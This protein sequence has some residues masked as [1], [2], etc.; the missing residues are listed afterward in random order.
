MFWELYDL[1]W[2][3]EKRLEEPELIAQILRFAA[4]VEADAQMR[5]AERILTMI[6]EGRIA[7]IKSYLEE[8]IS[9]LHEFQVRIDRDDSMHVFCDSMAKR[10]DIKSLKAVTP[11]Q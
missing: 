2:D 10:E 11:K 1:A 8:L 4:Y 6:E 7:F 9:S 5:L 3:L